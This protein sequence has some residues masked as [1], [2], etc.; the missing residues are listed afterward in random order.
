MR[1]AGT[2]WKKHSGDGKERT[3]G[4]REKMD[5]YVAAEG[6]EIM[7]KQNKEK[8]SERKNRNKRQ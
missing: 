6:E 2:G 3:R 5:Q 7:K 1:P 4:Q 8:E